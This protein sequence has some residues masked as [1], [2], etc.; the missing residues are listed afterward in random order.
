MPIEKGQKVIKELLEH[1][2]KPKDKFVHH[3]ENPGDMAMWDNTAVLHR[4]THGIYGN[5]YRRDLRRVSVF[6]TGSAAYGENAPSMYRNQA[7]P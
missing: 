3:W 6:N 4:A 5:K 1:I 7:A 2:Q